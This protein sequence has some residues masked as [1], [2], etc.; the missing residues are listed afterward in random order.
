MKYLT[1]IAL[2]L[3]ALSSYGQEIP[4]NS[5]SVILVSDS[6]TES[7]IAEKLIDNGFEIAS[8][9]AYSL[10]TEKKKIKSWLYDIVVT[11][12]KGGYKMSIY[13]N[14][15]ISLNYGYGVS[16]GPERMKAKYKGMKSSGFKVGWR[17][18]IFIADS[19]EVPLKYE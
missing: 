19:F 14:S 10:K 12:I 2:I 5:E 11:K 9:N 6:L 4:K 8:V 7:I 15:N 16:S 18:L 17:E 13:L 3:A 1:S